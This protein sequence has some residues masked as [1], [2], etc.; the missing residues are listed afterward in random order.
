MQKGNW[1]PLIV[2][3]VAAY[4]LWKYS[5][6]RLASTEWDFNIEVL[7][8]YT[9][10]TEA[11][12]CRSADIDSSAEALVRSGYLPTT[13]VSPSLAVSLKTLELFHR[14]RIC[15]PSFSIEVFAKVLCDIYGVSLLIITG[16]Y[17]SFLTSAATAQQ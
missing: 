17:I 11:H 1:K 7:D 2:K 14:I 13:P 15:K 6:T 12:I 16:S 10:D 9:L 8:L 3:L 5:S 4:I